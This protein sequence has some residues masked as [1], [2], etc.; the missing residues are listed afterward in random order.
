MKEK[1]IDIKKPAELMKVTPQTVKR[2][3]NADNH[4][5]YPVTVLFK[6]AR[7]LEVSISTII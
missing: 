3:F 7:A 1:C 6:I 4:L 5:H 2:F